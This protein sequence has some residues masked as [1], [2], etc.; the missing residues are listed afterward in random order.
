MGLSPWDGGET[1]AVFGGGQ[2]GG[3]PLQ[4]EG[5]QFGSPARG[6]RCIPRAPGRCHPLPSRPQVPLKGTRRLRRAR[7]MTRYPRSSPCAPKG[8]GRARR[9]SPRWDARGLGPPKPR[10]VPAE[11]ET[12]AGGVPAV[13]LF[14]GALS[15]QSPGEGR[16]GLPVS[17]WALPRGVFL[18]VWFRGSVDFPRLSCSGPELPSCAGFGARGAGSA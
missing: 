2:Q 13:P 15:L 18:G 9:I 1:L 10:C 7:R 16:S 4:N 5:P 14:R 11:Q 17:S 8:V 12:A 6:C 3:F